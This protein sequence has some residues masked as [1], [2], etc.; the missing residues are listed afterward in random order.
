MSAKERIRI[1]AIEPLSANWNKLE[2]VDF[3]YVRANGETQPLTR[4]IYHVDDGATVLLYDAARRTVILVRQFRLPAYL[5]G[6][7]GDLLETPAGFLDGTEPEARMRQEVEE[8]TGYRIASMQKVFEAL[9]VPG[10]VTHA[11]HCF[12]AAYTPQD[13]VSDGGGLVAEG[14]DIEVV[15]LLVDD[16]LAMIG[17]GEI[18]DGKTIMLLQYAALSLLRN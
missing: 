1:T 18:T 14:E 9:M 11:V 6:T 10:C 3:Q 7:S 12:V 16:A 2:K 13:K 4:E 15:E 17:R 5:R 8:E